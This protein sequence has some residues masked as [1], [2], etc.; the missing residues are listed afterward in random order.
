MATKRQHFVPRVYMKA[1]ETQ[2]ETSREPNR[3]FE[4]VYV[5]EN[6]NEIGEGANRNSILW[7]PHLYTIKFE[8]LFIVNS[9]PKIYSDFVDM[10]YDVMRNR[11]LQ[12]I[13][14]KDGYSIIKTK[15]SI[16]K[17]LLNIDNW[18]FYYDDGNVAKQRSIKNQI[19]SLNSYVL[20]SA[21][22]ECFETRWEQNLNNFIES[23]HNGIPVAMGMSERVIPVESAMNMLSFFFMMLCRSPQFDSM[24]IYTD[25]KNNIL[26]PI[27][28]EMCISDDLTTQEE[29]D[30]AIEEG[31]EYA[32]ELMTGIWYSEL[33]K[34]I[35][36]NKG[37]FYH[38]TLVKAIKDCQMILFEAYDDAGTFITSDNPAFEHISAV[39][40]ENSNGFVFPISPKYLL[41]IA[42]G[43][44]KINIV[45]HRFANAD[46]VK[47][48]NQIIKQHKMNML[49]STEKNIRKIL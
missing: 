41:F 8:Y 18:E 11:T 31:K 27:F 46:T 30:A 49:I 1:W 7:K 6:S 26:Y 43:A 36:K 48:F 5:F 44:D 4:G 28:E 21:F 2:V 10:V 9:C 15:K 12:P 33:Y 29:I 40:R 14:G 42:K 17:H 47:H 38:G 20:E 16:R 39:T 45:D 32:N 34:M 19:E 23:V 25:I 35:Y 22:D 24:G 3:K 37:G 13:Y